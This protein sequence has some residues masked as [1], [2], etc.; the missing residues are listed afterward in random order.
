VDV[1]PIHY[2]RTADGLNI[3]YQVV[4]DGLFDLV[5]VP[6]V[7]SN[8][9]LF[10]ENTRW[11]SFMRNLTAFSRLILF[12]RRGVGLSDRPSGVPAL[13]QRMD[14]GRA[15]MDAVASER[16]ARFGAGADGAMAALF[17]ATYPERVSALV[18]YAVPPRGLWA[19][20]Y[21][22][23]LRE[24][25][26]RNVVEEAERRFAQPDYLA[27]GA[28]RLFPSVADDDEAKAFQDYSIRLSVSPGAFAALRR[29]NFDID[30][31]K[32]LPTIRVPTLVLHRTG[33]RAV[34][35]EVS[36]FVAQQIPGAV[37]HELEG[38]DHFPWVGGPDALIAAVRGFVER[39]WREK[40]WE[41]VE[42][43]RVLATV[44]FTDIVGSTEKALA[45]GDARW[46]ELLSEHHVRVRGQLA[47]FRGREID[48]AGDGFFASFDGPARAIRCACAVRDVLNELGIEIRAGLHA[49]ECELIDGKAGGV[50]VHI[51][52]RVA[53][54]A[55][56]GE[57]LVSSTVK[58]L[59]AGSGIRFEDRGIHELKG[60]G[61]WHLFTVESASTA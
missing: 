21:P 37:Y 8:I 46:R 58:D 19:P 52:A 34:P 5:F 38:I 9:Q 10:W 36:R 15:V 32:V 51:G 3:A 14:D 23:G 55:A 41:E 47:R 43:D 31:R 28:N 1:P 16:A 35:V 45:L 26:A 49:G 50:A 4:G 22:W 6:Q 33:D 53:A 2:A 12:D 61:E 11:A 24:D 40:P 48:T 60:V 54:E 30:I 25:A 17:A 27:E 57:V 29:M 13:E 7:V 18:L 42:P 59:V 56:P 20:D 44:L 39:V